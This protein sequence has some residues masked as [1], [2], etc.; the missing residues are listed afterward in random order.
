MAAKQAAIAGE[1]DPMCYDYCKRNIDAFTWRQGFRTDHKGRGDS[2][3][4]FFVRLLISLWVWVWVWIPTVVHKQKFGILTGFSLIG[5]RYVARI[6]AGYGGWLVQLM[7]TM[8]KR[9]CTHACQL[10]QIDDESLQMYI[11]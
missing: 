6:L 11:L 3:F 2:W 9:S 4:S 10:V 5:S 7:T 1:L 8:T